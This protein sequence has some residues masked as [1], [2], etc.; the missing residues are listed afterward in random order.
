M[1]KSQRIDCTKGKVIGNNVVVSGAGNTRESDSSRAARDSGMRH[2]HGHNWKKEKK[3][4][5]LC[6]TVSHL[7]SF[8]F[9]VKIVEPINQL[10]G[11]NEKCDDGSVWKIRIW[12]EFKVICCD[13]FPCQCALWG[14]F[15]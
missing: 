1:K 13:F 3:T 5:L 4:V 11:C 12:V 10:N 6:F 14:Y 9:G 7:F 8:L 2:G 15:D